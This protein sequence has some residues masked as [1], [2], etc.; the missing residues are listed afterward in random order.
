MSQLKITDSSIQEIPQEHAE[1]LYGIN[2]NVI[3]TITVESDD[4]DMFFPFFAVENGSLIGDVR[5]FSGGYCMELP[6][7][8]SRDSFGEN[9]HNGIL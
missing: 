1:K 5:V 9:Y 3:F 2:Q 7:E 8:Q 6:K 4:G